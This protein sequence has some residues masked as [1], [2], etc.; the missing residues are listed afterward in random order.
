MCFGDSNTWGYDAERGYRMV[1]EIR[2]PGVMKNKFGENFTIIEE[3]LCG[4]TTVFDDPVEGDKSG[5]KHLTPLLHSHAPLDLII[6]MLGTNDL[7]DRFSASA[8]DIAGGVMRLVDT[9]RKSETPFTGPPPEI[10]IV[11]PPAPGDMS[12]SLFGDIFSEAEGKY[13][14]L[15]LLLKNFTS[16]AEIKFIN[17]E[18]CEINTADNLHLSKSG[19]K[20]LGEMLADFINNN[21]IK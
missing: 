9:V 5:L 4:R 15:G 10:V 6:I 12:K 3:G 20:Q 1:P 17:A 2:W 14:N 19:H 11:C 8:A 16:A 18:K 7:K 13:S 21:F